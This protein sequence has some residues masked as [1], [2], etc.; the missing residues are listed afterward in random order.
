[1]SHLKLTIELINT[2]VKQIN[3]YFIIYFRPCLIQDPDQIHI[4]FVCVGISDRNEEN[5]SLSSNNNNIVKRK[6]GKKISFSE[7]P[8]THIGHSNDNSMV[9][10]S[11]QYEKM[12]NTNEEKEEIVVD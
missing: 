2:F 4:T 1:M 10:M 12:E 8:V 6:E 7:P 5:V 9:N 11:S 3:T